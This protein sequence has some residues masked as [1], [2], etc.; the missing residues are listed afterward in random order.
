VGSVAER[1]LSG[2]VRVRGIPS[3]KNRP[4]RVHVLKEWQRAVGQKHPA[5][6]YPSKAGYTSRRKEPPGVSVSGIFGGRKRKDGRGT[7]REETASNVRRMKT[8]KVR[9]LKRARSPLLPEKGGRAGGCRW[10]RE[11][12]PLECRCQAV[13]S[14]RKAQ[15]RRNPG[16]PGFSRGVGTKP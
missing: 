1:S 5:G 6:R 16:K 11:L 2:L 12:K 15:E 8:W 9:K 13:R 10:R 14:G 7:K 4:R 3:R